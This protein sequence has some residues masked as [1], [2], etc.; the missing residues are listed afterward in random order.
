MSHLLE[1]QK[2]NDER[3]AKLADPR[4]LGLNDQ[5]VQPLIDQSYPHYYISAPFIRPKRAHPHP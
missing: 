5:Q 2:A 1:T 4:T 3:L